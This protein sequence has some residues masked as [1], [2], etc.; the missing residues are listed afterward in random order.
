MVTGG[1]FTISAFPGCP[2]LSCHRLQALSFLTGACGEGFLEAGEIPAAPS[3][4]PRWPAHHVHTG[5]LRK[6]LRRVTGVGGLTAAHRGLTRNAL[7]CMKYS[8]NKQSTQG[9]A[10]SIGRTSF[11]MS[12]HFIKIIFSCKKRCGIRR[13]C[14]DQDAS[15]LGLDCHPGEQRAGGG[16]WP[17]S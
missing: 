2:C 15:L 12:Q 8:S 10:T 1:S 16:C 13:W 3:A 11:E 17:W 14:T 7:T 5:T 4:S 9:S 6:G